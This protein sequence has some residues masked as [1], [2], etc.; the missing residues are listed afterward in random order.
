[1]SPSPRAPAPKRH[2]SSPTP[3][4][5]HSKVTLAVSKAL[6]YAAGDKPGGVSD[7]FWETTSSLIHMLAM[8][9][10]E[11]ASSPHLLPPPPPT[12]SLPPSSLNPPPPSS[13]THP[14]PLFS[15]LNHSTPSP[16]L[17]LL[18]SSIPPPPSLSS[19]L[20][21]PSLTP[22][23]PSQ[24]TPFSLP[25]YEEY[26]RERSIVISGV[27]ESIEPSSVVRA[28]MDYESVKLILSALSVESLPCTVFRM[29]R[30]STSSP[31]I[32]RLIKVV[33][34]ARAHVFKALSSARVLRTLPQFPKVYVR[35][36]MT[37]EERQR[38]A[39]L[40][41]SLRDLRQADANCPFVVYRGELWSREEIKTGRRTT[42]PPLEGNGLL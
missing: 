15:S 2:M 9:L 24:S 26:L 6:A 18:S 17:S 14:P 7:G 34:P 21:H 30:V 8:L 3:S 25:S 1:M 36:S 19:S 35:K 23:P 33:L 29:G 42:L 39:S 16:P 31:P 32:P 22:S 20:P 4:D 27:P 5:S 11:V 28:E 12:P 37:L 41:A 38:D 40:R 13:L 10:E